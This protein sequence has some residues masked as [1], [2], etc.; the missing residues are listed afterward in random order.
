M[1]FKEEICSLD[2]GGLTGSGGETVEE[3]EGGGS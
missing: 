2:V 1:S 3:F